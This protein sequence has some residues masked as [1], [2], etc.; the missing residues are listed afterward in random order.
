MNKLLSP[1]ALSISSLIEEIEQFQWE[2]KEKIQDYQLQQL[3]NLL[4]YHN[5][6]NPFYSNLLK[7]G[8]VKV[9][10]N[11]DLHLKMLP[12]LKRRDIQIIGAN[13]FTKKIP[14]DHS[15]ISQVQT[16]GSTG[17]PVKINKTQVNSKLWAAY[18]IRE[19]MWNQ[20]NFGSKLS[21]IRPTIDEYIEMDSWGNPV[22]SFYQT[23]AGQGIP[24][25]T[26]IKEQLRLLKQFSPEVL[27]IYPNNLKGL[28]DDM[29]GEG[30]L[31][32]SIKHIKTV[33]E[34]VNDDLR[35]FTK[36]FFG[37][38]IEDSYSSQELGTIA[39]QCPNSG[40]YH[41]MSESIMLE[42]LDKNNEPCKEGEIGR[43]VVTDLHNYASPVIRYDIGDYAEAGGSCNC[44]R[45]FPTIKR[46]VGRERNLITKPDG[47]KHWP[48]F[49]F[50]QFDI[51]A[52]I[53]QYQFVQH[54]LTLIEMRV[55][56]KRK[57][58]DT[59]KENLA[60]I[61][62]NVLNAPFNIE[63]VELQEALQSKAGK[64]E[65]FISKV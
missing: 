59:D 28:I 32:P 3:F 10:A 23:G 46:I 11:L 55:F 52:P 18:T 27:I 17:E 15:P 50:H 7:K 65:E 43:V 33:G 62:K 38:A 39:I 20:R 40:L 36:D 56:P 8:K 60:C 41:V 53:Y 26:P 12:I 51:V 9:R 1:S 30:L 48:I 19:H 5:R 4:S 2:T 47:S 44:G 22:S 13:F 29:R 45:N 14:A 21:S 49:G 6:H 63:I 34:T 35:K 61:V 42:V 54:S 31:L 64:F 57:L 24:I 37:I 25:T 16:S 58:T